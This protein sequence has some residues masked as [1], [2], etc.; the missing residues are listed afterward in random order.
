MFYSSRLLVSLSAVSE[1]NVTFWWTRSKDTK[2]STC[3]SQNV[4]VEQIASRPPLSAAVATFT[5]R[6]EAAARCIKPFPEWQPGDF[7]IAA[8][9]VRINHHSEEKLLK[10]KEK[11][12]RYLLGAKNAVNSGRQRQQRAIRGTR[13]KIQTRRLGGG[14]GR[15]IFFF[16]F[17]FLLPVPSLHLPGVCFS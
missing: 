8:T 5:R 10:K 17:V 9:R 7:I 2:F 13:L 12:R 4:I 16:G 1:G 3:I 14:A 11:K 15:A 6:A